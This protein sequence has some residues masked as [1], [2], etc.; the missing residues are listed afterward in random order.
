M[1]AVDITYGVGL[2]DQLTDCR[3]VGKSF[4]AA[5]LALCLT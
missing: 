3:L 5:K 2:I 4:L 1:G